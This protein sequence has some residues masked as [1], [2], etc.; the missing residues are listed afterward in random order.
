MIVGGRLFLLNLEPMKRRIRPL[1]VVMRFQRVL[2][3]DLQWHDGHGI[4]I[5]DGYF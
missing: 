3:G 4:V 2:A 1:F 5:V